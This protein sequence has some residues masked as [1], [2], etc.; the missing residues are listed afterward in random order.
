MSNFKAI[1]WQIW[2]CIL[3]AIAW[4]QF[5]L[6]FREEPGSLEINAYGKALEMASVG[7]FNTPQFSEIDLNLDGIN[8]LF[9]FDRAHDILRTFVFDQQANKYHY[10]PEYEAAFP[11]NLKEF[12]LLR[13]YDCDGKADIFTYNQAGFRVFRNISSS[14]GIA[15]NL[16]TDKV[17]SNYGSF[18]TAAFVLAG[19]IPAIVDVDAD[20]DLDILTFGTVNSENTIE[21]HR[22]LSQEL[23]NNCDSLE[24]EVVTQCWGNVQE[25][26]NSSALLPISC[27][28]VVPPHGREELH[29]GSTVLLVDTDNDGDKDLIIGDIQ[30]DRV[31]H[32]LN[33][34]DNQNASIDVNLQTQLFPNTTDP[35]RM[36]YLVAGYEIDVDKDGIM[37]LIMSVNNAIDSSANTGHIWHYRNT[38]AGAANYDLANDEFLIGEML[39]LGANTSPVAMD[40]NSDG[41]IDLLVANDFRRTPD[42]STGSRIYYFEQQPDRSFMLEDEDFSNISMFGFS[43]AQIALGDMDNDGDADMILGDADGYLHYFTNQTIGGMAEFTLSQPEFM[44]INTIGSNAAPEIADINE[45]GLPDLLVGERIGVI[46]YFENFGTLSTPSFTSFPTISN[47]GAIDVSKLCC[48]GYSAPRLVDNAAFG[49]GR[50]LFVGSSEKRVDIFEL[51]EN[52]SEILVRKD[53]LLFNSGRLTPLPTDLDNDGIYEMICGTAEG[54]IK[55]YIRDENYTVGLSET[56]YKSAFQLKVYPNPVNDHINLQ[57]DSVFIGEIE[58]A[59]ISGQTILSLPLNATHLQIETAHLPS[60]IYYIT[61]RNKN[62]TTTELVAIFH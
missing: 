48:S 51:G 50:Y 20:G 35:V 2:F 8:D 41:L 30:T 6:G 61:A 45:D 19:D 18:T 29:P 39:D 60:G 38:S 9:V 52:L 14:S 17:L 58:L 62:Q 16:I 27:K 11:D 55:H 54:G 57:F 12:V 3:P 37:D 46:S 34:G 15:F 21:F 23:Y 36:Q 44:G 56:I 22:N 4:A 59:N 1:I 40:V 32:A 26:V 7:G 24:F 42:Q 28:G 31:V 33:T 53:S 13:D 49:T 5:N 43:A 47:F 10:A 25:P